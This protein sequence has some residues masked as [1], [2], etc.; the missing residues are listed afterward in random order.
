MTDPYRRLLQVRS[1]ARLNPLNQNQDAFIPTKTV[2]A[3]IETDNP[4]D[5]AMASNTELQIAGGTTL[6]GKV[7]AK[8]LTFFSTGATINVKSAT[9]TESSNYF[10]SSYDTTHVQVA[11]NNPDGLK[12]PWKGTEKTLPRI[13]DTKLDYYKSLATQAGGLVISAANGNLNLIN[14]SDIYPPANGSHIYFCEEGDMNIKGTIHGQ[15]VFVSSGTVTLAGDVKYDLNTPPLDQFNNPMPPGTVTG[16]GFFSS[17]NVLIG[18]NA[19][20]ALGKL[21][22]NGQIIA[23]NGE[24]KAT[25]DV[26]G[27]LA[28]TEFTFKGSVIVKN[29]VNIAGVYTKKRTYTFDPILSSNPLPN[30]PYMANIISWKEE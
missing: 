16:A 7:Y 22:I 13:D 26:N 25:S 1:V 11:D 10:D 27:S 17:K 14:G 12:K 2:I 6:A 21:E 20:D 9:F 15:I 19:S 3:V 28:T 5:Y 30:M 29:G 18:V 24:F 8:K 23:P 4:G